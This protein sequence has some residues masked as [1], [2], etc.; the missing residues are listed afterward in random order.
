MIHA[1]PLFFSKPEF[2]VSFNIAA[3]SNNINIALQYSATTRSQSILAEI[4]PASWRPLSQRCGCQHQSQATLPQRPT[5]DENAAQS[6]ARRLREGTR[7]LSDADRTP[8]RAHGPVLRRRSTDPRR[9]REMSTVRVPKRG[10]D[11]WRCV[12][13]RTRSHR[14]R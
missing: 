13:E 7:P 3:S 4:L 1:D 8:A 12:S 2:D 5:R 6:R 14:N 11:S 10:R 9:Y